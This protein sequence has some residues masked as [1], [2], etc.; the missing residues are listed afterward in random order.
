MARV[1]VIEDDLPTSNQLAGWIRAAKPGIEVHQYGAHLF[2]TSNATVWEYVN[3]FT[4]FT[5]YVHRVYTTHKGT[6]FP[7][8]VNL[9][10]GIAT[11]ATDSNGVDGSLAR[12]PNGVD[13]D[14]AATD[15][16]F[17]GSPTPGA[18]NTP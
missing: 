3:R 11:T 2:H 9:V 5:S 15:W 16:A 14:N 13:T 4:T 12:L 18:A 10:E 17:S 1:A 8:P 7:M 6:V